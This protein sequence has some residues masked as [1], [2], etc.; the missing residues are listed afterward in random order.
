MSTAYISH[1]DCLLHGT[2]PIHPE[3]ASRLGAINDRLISAHLYDFLRHYD[4]PEATREQLLQ[5]HD[6]GYLEWVEE[7]LPMSGYAYLDPDT[8]ISPDSLK[9]ARR[10]AG[11]VV[12]GVDLVME[13][14][15]NNAFCA[16]RPPG[17]HAEQD[18]AM[19]F[20]VYGNV[21]A[22]AAHALEHHGLERVAVLDFDVHF[23]NGTENIFHNDH[24]VLICN[25]FQKS[26]YPHIPCG[27]RAKSS[28]CAPL[29]STAKGMEFRA[30][31][32]SR[33][34]PAMRDFQPQLILVSAG[35][36]AH[37]EDDMSDVSLTE[38][39]Y[40]WVTERI[41]ELAEQYSEGRIVSSLEGGYDLS[42]L[43]RSVETHLRVLMGL[44]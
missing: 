36:D 30:A 43:G 3:C 17:H 6:A 22:G 29:E 7:Q 16:V 44:Q 5:I 24:R 39:D 35:F 42:A 18:R 31:V 32:E 28:I 2:G 15:V 4:A 14:Q 27:G 26:F 40:R 1:P 23:G 37:A 41:V 12:L 8:M 34:L 9:A 25:T 19:G 20:C 13:G 38:A 33:W 10:A 21:A 11:A